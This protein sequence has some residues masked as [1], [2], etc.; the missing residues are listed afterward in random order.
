MFL[1]TDQI[2]KLNENRVF[3]RIK[4]K[5]NCLTAEQFGCK[6]ENYQCIDIRI[7]NTE[8]DSESKRIQTIN[9]TAKKNNES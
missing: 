1:L 7:T 6:S 4:T 5:N 2:Q 8:N 9:Y 3:V